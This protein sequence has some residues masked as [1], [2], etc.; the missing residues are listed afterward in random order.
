MRNLEDEEKK[1]SPSTQDTKW[2]CEKAAF[3]YRFSKFAFIW[4]NLGLYFIIGSVVRLGLLPMTASLSTDFFPKDVCTGLLSH[5]FGV[6]EVLFLR[7]MK[8]LS[9]NA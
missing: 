3:K 8:N 9:F 1:I 4:T 5:Q 7:K 6:V 2:N